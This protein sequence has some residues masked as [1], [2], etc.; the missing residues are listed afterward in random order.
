MFYRC[1]HG[2]DLIGLS[3]GYWSFHQDCSRAQNPMA[4]YHIIKMDVDLLHSLARGSKPM[5]P[6][7][8]EGRT[9]QFQK[10]LLV[11][12]RLGMLFT[13]NRVFNRVLAVD[14]VRAKLWSK[15]SLIDERICEKFELYHHRVLDIV[16]FRA[17]IWSKPYCQRTKSF[18]KEFTC[19]IF[20]RMLD[21]D[22][23]RAKL[24]SKPSR[25]DERVYSHFERKYLHQI[26][27]IRKTFWLLRFHFFI[28]QLQAQG[29]FLN[30]PLNFRK[31]SLVVYYLKAIPWH[32]VQ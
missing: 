14:I 24:C 2:F 26:R 5:F 8:N 29:A 15:P 11:S 17:N 32:P 27:M 10:S 4:L 21:V 19:Y 9:E 12:H 6:Q 23:F 3:V 28:C 30:L 1:M 18:L 7:S 16:I 20:L 25:E 22:I 31:G 13:C